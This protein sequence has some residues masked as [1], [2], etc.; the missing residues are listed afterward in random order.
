MDTTGDAYTSLFLS[1]TGGPSMSVTQAKIRVV[2]EEITRLMTI[3][4][5]GDVRKK[6]VRE[7]AC[8]QRD[9]VDSSSRQK[10]ELFRLNN[11]HVPRLHPQ[12]DWTERVVYQASLMATIILR[13]ETHKEYLTRRNAVEASLLLAERR[14]TFV[15]LTHSRVREDAVFGGLPTEMIERLFNDSISIETD[16]TDTSGRYT[17][18]GGK[19]IEEVD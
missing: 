5:A 13:E 6:L 14:Y 15:M 19:W 2:K 4:D 9:I 16:I 17:K 3:L 7:L 1:L 18:Y 8:C 10:L 12:W 11:G